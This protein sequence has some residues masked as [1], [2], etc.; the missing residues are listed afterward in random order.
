MTR[1]G[2][3]DWGRGAIGINLSQTLAEEE[4]LPH[5]A[6]CTLFDTDTDLWPTGN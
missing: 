2:I 6:A 4:R 1:E 5:T 3:C